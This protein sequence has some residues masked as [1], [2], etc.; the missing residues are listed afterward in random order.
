MSTTTRCSKDLPVIYRGTKSSTFSVGSSALSL[1]TNT[2]SSSISVFT[3]I[4]LPGTIQ[5]LT[6]VWKMLICFKICFF[7][8]FCL[9]ITWIHY[10]T[11]VYS[12]TTSFIVNNLFKQFEIRYFSESFILKMSAFGRPSVCHVCH[13][14]LDLLLFI[15]FHLFST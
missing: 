1:F 3:N 7:F 12:K 10:L 9:K 6:V 14:L 13:E 15:F 11:L 4:S 8:T 2:S 5:I